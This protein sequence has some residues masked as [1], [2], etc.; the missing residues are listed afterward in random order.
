[1]I[2][3]VRKAMVDPEGFDPKSGLFGGAS[4]FEEL[5]CAVDNATK[6]KSTSAHE[7][8]ENDLILCLRPIETDI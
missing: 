6:K 1:M 8:V 5:I 2:E 7:P 4:P 3:E